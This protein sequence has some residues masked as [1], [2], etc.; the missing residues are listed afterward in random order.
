MPFFNMIKQIE[1]ETVQDFVKSQPFLVRPKHE[2]NEIVLVIYFEDAY[3]D[4]IEIGRV[5]KPIDFFTGE[6]MVNQ[7][8]DEWIKANNEQVIPSGIFKNN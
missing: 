7:A 8:I 2:H 5:N 4:L 6:N 1:V 3:K